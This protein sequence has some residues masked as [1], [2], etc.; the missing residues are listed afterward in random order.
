M[1]DSLFVINGNCCFIY[2]P[3]LSSKNMKGV[4]ILITH[5]KKMLSLW[6]SCIV[7]TDLKPCVSGANNP[8]KQ[9]LLLNAYAFD[10]L[11]LYVFPL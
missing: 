8:K 2:Y 9:S 5:T 7:H 11:Y 4:I 6:E 1:V 10:Y 3:P